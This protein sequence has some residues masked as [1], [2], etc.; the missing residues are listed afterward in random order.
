MNII[1][2]D[3][4]EIAKNPHGVAAK[5]VFQNTY[6]EIMHVELKPGEHLEK[7]HM[8]VDVLFYIIEGSGIIQLGDESERVSKNTLI[9]SPAGVA[10]G[11][12]N[13]GE[14][15]LRILVIKCPKPSP[16]EKRKAISEIKNAKQNM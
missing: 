8:P 2:I 11:W 3:E 5:K 12:I 4:L 9:E 15:S 1:K 6:N 14:E 7:H 13:N 10:R 16:D